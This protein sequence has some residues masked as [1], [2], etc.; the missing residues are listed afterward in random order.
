MK[1]INGGKILD[2]GSYGC[3]FRPS[4]YCKT[5][6]SYKTISKLMTRDNALQEYELSKRIE[7]HLAQIPHYKKYFVLVTDMCSI[8]EITD[9]DLED[10]EKCKI[11]KKNNISR[12]DISNI[13]KNYIILN[14][15]YG[16]IEIYDYIKTNIF[17]PELAKFV[18][19]SIDLLKN[20]IIPMNSKKVYHCDLKSNNILI[21]ENSV[22]LIDWGL[23]L[24]DPSIDDINAN[25]IIINQ[26]FGSLFFHSS[27]TNISH[28]PEFEIRSI[29][30]RFLSNYRKNDHYTSFE[31]FF[32]LLFHSPIETYIENYLFNIIKKYSQAEYYPIFLANL[33]I[34]GFL[35]Y[36]LDI[37]KLLK[38]HAIKENSRLK[39]IRELL[40]YTYTCVDKLDI[41]FIVSKME[42]FAK[43]SK[44]TK[45]V[46]ASMGGRRTRR[47]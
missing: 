10:Y 18:R 13:K 36:F 7:S 47:R 2:S 42:K 22:R 40:D 12:Q 33:D 8:S 44:K 35:S 15:P 5:A 3:V 17:K 46:R 34:W 37:T 43:L 9:S 31:N 20:G 28:L 41:G 19:K 39:I 16:G 32:M 23:S 38:P 27:F 26:P 25:Y 21:D 1:I 6:P 11:L 14:Q 30:R 24:I 45:S 4:L 29:I